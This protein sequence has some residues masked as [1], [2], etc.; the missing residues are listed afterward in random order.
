VIKSGEV[1][2]EQFG[3]LE[4]TA[5][6]PNAGEFSVA[7]VDVSGENRRLRN[8]KS[9]SAYSVIGGTGMFI[10]DGRE[11]PVGAGD[12]VFIPRG[13]VYQDKGQLQLLSVN[14]PPFDA[15]AIEYL[16]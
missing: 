2:K 3:V 8:T 12:L 15:T 11:I 14:T 5:L 9:D 1:G 6:L 16:D 4:V 7:R 13:H 10:L